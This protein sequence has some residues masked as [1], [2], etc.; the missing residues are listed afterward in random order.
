[1]RKRNKE[2]VEVFMSDELK[3]KLR[4]RADLLS[5]GMATV[6]KVALEEYLNKKI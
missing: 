2:K 4:T 6:I 5:I 3:E 1:M